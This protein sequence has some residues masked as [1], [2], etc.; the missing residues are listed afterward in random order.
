MK[1]LREWLDAHPAP[2]VQARPEG[3]E[4]SYSMVRTYMDCPWLFKIVYQDRKRPPYHPRSALGV[5][6]HR[7][8]EAFHREG[9]PDLERLL[10]LYDEG[11]VHAGFSDAQE[12]LEW[13]RKGA[14]VLEGYWRREEDRRSQILGVEKEFLFPLGPH[15]VRGSIDRVDRRPDGTIEVIDYKTHLDIASEE[16]VAQDLQ[17]R[18][19]GLG[20][21]ESLG[22]DPAWLSLDYVAVGK[23]VTVPYDAAREDEVKELLARVGDLIA[24]GKGL[25]PDTTHCAACDFRASCPHSIARS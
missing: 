12:Q 11:W 7:A 2:P 5:S 3:V 25:R 13:H 8:L 15:R 4:L 23:R 17:L 20:V 14:R 16:S 18:I 1:P 9:A 24:W 22:L 6:I 21:K 10:E 19:Y